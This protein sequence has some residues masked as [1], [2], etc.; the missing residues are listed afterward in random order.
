MLA[1]EGFNRPGTRTNSGMLSPREMF[2]EGHPLMLFLPL[3]KLAYHRVPRRKKMG[4]QAR[5]CLLPNFGYNHGSDRLNGAP[6]TWAEK[7]YI[8]AQNTDETVTRLK[9]LANGCEV[10]SDLTK[11]NSE[12]A[13]EPSWG[14]SGK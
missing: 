8:W 4:P 11:G 14:P 2:Y 9:L 7:I 3:C 1:C 5:P 10:K 13:G 12:N 6:R